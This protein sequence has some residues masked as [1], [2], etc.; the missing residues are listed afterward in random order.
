MS[1]CAGARPSRVCE[2]TCCGARGGCH[3]TSLPDA[4]SGFADIAHAYGVDLYQCGHVHNYLRFYPEYNGAVD[5]ACASVPGVYQDPKYMITLVAGSPGCQEHIS[6]DLGPADALVV[7]SL[8]YG[9]GL[10]KAINT[11]HATWQWVQ[12]LK[13]TGSKVLSEPQYERVREVKD[14]LTIIQTNHG[15]RAL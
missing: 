7:S 10:F 2:Y 5:K 13:P 8:T 14:E 15:P 11:T 3:L 1:G 4:R 9:F 12:T 6:T